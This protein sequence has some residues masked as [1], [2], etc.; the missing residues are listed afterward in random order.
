MS[1]ANLESEGGRGLE[2]MRPE[3]FSIFRGLNPLT[4]GPDY[5][6]LLFFY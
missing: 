2:D 4:T 5:I 1:V 6:R 3:I